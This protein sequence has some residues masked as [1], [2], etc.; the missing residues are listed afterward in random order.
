MATPSHVSHGIT[1]QGSGCCHSRHQNITA[2]VDCCAVLMGQACIYWDMEHYSK[3]Q[4]ILQQSTD[5]CSEHKAWKLNCAHT[6]F[7]Q[8]GKALGQCSHAHVQCCAHL[9]FRRSNLVALF[10]SYIWNAITCMNCRCQYMHTFGTGLLST[11]M[12]EGHALI[13]AWQYIFCRCPVHECFQTATSMHD[14]NG[15]HAE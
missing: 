12:H 2:C 3:V 5:F 8:G 1:G 11:Y 15:D 7:M 10:H 4:T 13:H 14:S 6:L 9:N